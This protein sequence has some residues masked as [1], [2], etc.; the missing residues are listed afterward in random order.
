MRNA[1][2]KEV[3]QAVDSA[4]TAER[5][6]TKYLVPAGAAQELARALARE[7]RPH[8]FS[9]PFASILPGGR[10]YATTIYFDTEQRDLYREA[11]A[12][13]VHCKIR[14]REYYSVH[15]SLTDLATDP[16]QLV[17]YTPFV[18]LVV[19]YRD[20]SQTRK[21]RFGMPKRDLG[22]FLETG[23]VSLQ[24]LELLQP[25]YGAE[26]ASVLA[27]VVVICRRHA[28]PLRPDCV[29]NYRRSAWQDEPGTLRVTLDR[30]VAFFAPSPDLFSRDFALV[31]ETLGTPAGGLGAGVM[32]IKARG[33]LPAWLTDLLAEHGLEPEHMSK[34]VAASRTIHG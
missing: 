4:L 5:A 17:R 16:R 21:R 13:E 9:G 23:A 27:E 30:A 22:R 33:A 20:A 19:K 14:A 24:M 26:A 34:F 12:S 10:D 29:V 3:S 25:E 8:R 7:L 32:E 15:P 11:T 2:V 31:R 1:A 28:T 18:W 6:E